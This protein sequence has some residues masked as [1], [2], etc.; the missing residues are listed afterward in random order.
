MENFNNNSRIESKQQVY[1]ESLESL[2]TLSWIQILTG[3]MLFAA[4][5][6]LPSEYYMFLRIFVFIVSIWSIKNFILIIMII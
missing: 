2:T 5:D 6:D 1:F 4:L 3:C